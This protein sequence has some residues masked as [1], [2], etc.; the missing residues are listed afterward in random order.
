[1]F[2]IK[3]PPSSSFSVVF[4]QFPQFCMIKE[5]FFLRDMTPIFIKDFAGQD[6]TQLIA[7]G[8]EEDNDTSQK[9][10]HHHHRC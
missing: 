10:H 6:V 8:E 9:H 1:M 2:T 5:N 3:S 4:I 7:V